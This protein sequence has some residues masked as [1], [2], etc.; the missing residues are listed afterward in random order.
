MSPFEWRSELLLHIPE[1][2]GQHQELV[3]RASDLRNALD[4]ATPRHELQAMLSALI[5]SA[6]NHF[7]SEEKMMRAHRYN[8]YAPHAAEHADLLEQVYLIRRE[9]SSG[10]INPSVA[11][12]VFMQVWTEQHILGPDKQFAKSLSRPTD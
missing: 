11:L 7:R 4:A 2:D 10:K 5:E 12:M 8:G 1:I 6:E 9:F 3:A